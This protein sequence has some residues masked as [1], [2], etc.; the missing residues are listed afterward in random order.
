QLP[1]AQVALAWLLEQPNV[2]APIIGATKM[3][4]LED[5]AAAVFLKLSAEETKQLEASYSPHA[6]AGFS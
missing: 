1:N 5:A 6:I 2:T 4:H 3:Q